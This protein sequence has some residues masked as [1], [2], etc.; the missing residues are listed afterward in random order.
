MAKRLH[1]MQ[2]RFFAIAFRATEPPVKLGSAK[3]I[4]AAH[5]LAR[6]AIATNRSAFVEIRDARTR[7]VLNTVTQGR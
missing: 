5:R 6:E 2:N 4:A 1:P 3:T 7:Q